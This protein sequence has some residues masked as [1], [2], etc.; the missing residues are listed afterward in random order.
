[1][2]KENLLTT[3]IVQ[4]KKKV[5]TRSPNIANVKNIVVLIK[6]TKFQTNS[7]HLIRFQMQLLLSELFFLSLFLHNDH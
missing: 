1:M 6:V 5:S 4:S 7:S 2:L 3:N